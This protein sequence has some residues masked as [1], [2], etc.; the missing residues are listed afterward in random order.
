MFRTGLFLICTLFLLTLKA[1][2][3]YLLSE[4]NDIQPIGNSLLLFED[5][6]AN[7]SFEQL[8][9][10][11][12]Q[13]K[14]EPSDGAV[15]N[16]NVTTSVIWVKMLFTTR[17]TN[18]WC[19]EFGM[20][21]AQDI[22][23]YQVINSKPVIQKSGINTPGKERV[24]IGHRAIFELK[25]NK[26]DTVE[27]YMR[28]KDVAPIRIIVKA[29]SMEQFFKQ[30]HGVNFWHGAFFGIMLLMAIYNLFLF[31][32]NGNRVYI[33][34]VF[35]VLFSSLFIAFF[36]GY[37]SLFS[38]WLLLPFIYLPTFAPA[39]FG[40]FGLLFTMEFLHTKKHAPRMHKT[41]IYFMSSIVIPLF[42]SA[43]VSPHLGLILIQ[44]YGLALSILSI[45]VGIVVF[46]TGYRPAKF[47]LIGFGSYMTGLLCT[48]S[49]DFI[50]VNNEFITMYIFQA[51]AAVETVI[52]SFAIGDKLNSA[53]REKNI[54]QAKAL[55]ESQK[56]EKLIREQN[57]TLEQKVKERT[58]ELE[59]QKQVVEEKQNEIIDSIKYASR[60]QKALLPGDNAI[61]KDLKKLN[62]KNK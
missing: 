10:A 14:F 23:F 18:T 44:I 7:K 43:F 46:R 15:P 27:C 42:I 38:E 50:G 11:D 2:Q 8:L 12:M 36:N 53:N 58:R 41:M 31:I 19:V 17:E 5:V 49:A 54:A 60:I 9:Q 48:I 62:K 51:G 6:E 30:D 4:K 47:Y 13:A 20:P 29:G 34:Y 35:Y 59:E 45:S 52:L 40:L 57:I 3:P 28:V 39:M 33:Y 37:V 21:S 22:A 16:F 32:T 61:H 55:E 1:Q 25:L 56:N 26:G 24:L